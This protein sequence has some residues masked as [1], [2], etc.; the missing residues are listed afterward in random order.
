[1]LKGFL[2]GN[3]IGLFSGSALY[4][5]AK[6]VDIITG[7]LPISPPMFFALIY[8]ASVVSGIAHEYSEWLES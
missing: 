3:V 1:M 2:Y 6:A 5:L 4:L 8:G 7:G